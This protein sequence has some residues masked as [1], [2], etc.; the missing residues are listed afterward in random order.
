MSKLYDLKEAL[1]GLFVAG[2]DDEHSGDEMLDL[3]ETVNYDALM[4][5]LADTAGTLYAYAA[6]GALPYRGKALV[7]KKAAL[8]WVDSK[9][10]V[11]EGEVLYQHC[12]EL[13]LLDDMTFLVTS[14]YRVVYPDLFIS[15]YRTV[16]GMYP[17]ACDIRIDFVEL[18]DF[19]TY[20]PE[21]YSKNNVPIYE[22]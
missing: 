6:S 9:V 3:L 21:M 7:E 10:S 18:S 19:L 14:C 17:A 2:A 22:L 16:K 11:L 5:V 13:W 12:T 15:F 4:N 20:L 8:L 1:E